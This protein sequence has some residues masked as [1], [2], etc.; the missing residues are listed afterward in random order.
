MRR[1]HEMRNTLL[2]TKKI[3]FIKVEL[4]DERYQIECNPFKN[5]AFVS[6]VLT[7]FCLRFNVK[8]VA[9]YNICD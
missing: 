3:P 9:V 1:D 8:L 5:I 2:L 7:F 4:Q 6:S